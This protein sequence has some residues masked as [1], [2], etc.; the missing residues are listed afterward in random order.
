MAISRQELIMKA[1]LVAALAICVLEG[2]LASL[3]AQ[4]T[5]KPLR[6]CLVSGSVEYDSDTSLTSLQK[7][8]EKN[9]HVIC[10]K[11]FRASDSDLP[12]LENLDTCDV[13]VLFT[14]RLTI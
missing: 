5:T 14:R 1:Y 3:G 12:G 6:V 2:N 8:L 7:Y 11:A 10:S 13:M 4:S 9:Y